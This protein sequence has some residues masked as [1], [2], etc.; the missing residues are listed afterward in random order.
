M[1]EAFCQQRLLWIA[2]WSRD[3]GIRLL[4][5]PT[6][7]APGKTV[8][9]ICEASRA[10][11]LNDAAEYFAALRAA[12]LRAQ[13]QVYIIGWDIHSQMRLV[14]PSGCANDGF[15]EKLGEFLRALVRTR[16]ELRIHVLVWNFP[17][18]YAAERERNPAEKFRSGCIDRI[19][20]CLDSSLPLGSAQHQKIIVIDDAIAFVGGLD[21]TIRRWDTSEHL[22][23]NE[24]RKDPDGKPYP[25][26]HDVQCMVEGEV[27]SALADIARKRCASIGWRTQP[28]ATA[29]SER[30]PS[31]I[32]VHAKRIPVGIA[33][34]EPRGQASDQ[35]N[36]AECLFEASIGAAMRF[37][38]IESQFTTTS[39]VARLLARRMREI[40]SLC[41]LIVTPRAHSSWLET[42][43][44]Q[45]GR[46]SFM[47]AFAEAG[48][49]DRLRVAYPFVHDG[50]ESATVMV[51]SKLMIVDDDFLRIGSANLNNRS[52]GVDTECDLAFVACCE[53]HRAFIR[54]ARRRL[55]AH[56]CGAAEHEVAAAENDLVAFLDGLS[57]RRPRVMLIR[58]DPED[59]SSR[60]FTKII[61]PIADP[62][63]QLDVTAAARQLSSPKL[64]LPL[65]IPIISLVI[66]ALLWRYT[67]LGSYAE[68]GFVSGLIGH[69]SLAPL[70]AIAA[71]IFGGLVMFPVLVLIAATA[72]VLGPWLG[73]LTAAAGVLLSSLFSF[74]IGRALGRRPL[75]SLLGARANQIQSRIVGRGILPVLVI[76]MLPIAPF[77]LVN[78]LAGA[79]KMKLCEFLIGTALGMAPGI[80]AMAMLGSQIADFVEHASA[81]NILLMGLT[82]VLWILVCAGVQFVVTLLGERRQ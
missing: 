81:S 70:Y 27:A 14:G 24:S 38:Y 41:V 9:R 28:V 15:P 68:P 44:M 49:T 10:A 47:R 23:K 5:K 60:P 11:I 56:F 57:I 75:Q 33:R 35:V 76:R 59:A 77:S 50:H 79:T 7:L 61:Q 46:A 42:Q 52:M 43:T 18:L 30:W 58:L 3:Q 73:L 32:P 22:A 51:H 48:V 8:W 82:I 36:E 54:S 37:I 40:P 69:S 55:I 62:K 80:V 53:D 13:E 2:P 34:T 29:P 12:L 25:P 64:L 67:S 20:F 17:A 63:D 6:I 66:L 21:L 26:F 1:A 78:L 4:Q 71:F 16:P 31:S 72:I 74:L 45:G 39:E 65:G 19:Q